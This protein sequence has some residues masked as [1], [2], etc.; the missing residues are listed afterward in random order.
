MDN[1]SSVM[2]K[3]RWPTPGKN[4]EARFITGFSA[5]HAE[6]FIG[7]NLNAIL[8]T[9][10]VKNLDE[11]MGHPPNAIVLPSVGEINVHTTYYCSS[12]LV[13]KTPSVHGFIIGLLLAAKVS[14]AE[15]QR[16]QLRAN[17][18]SLTSHLY[19]IGGDGVLISF[20]IVTFFL[21]PRRA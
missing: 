15:N 18:N 8:C 19:I 4:E 16:K 14:Q 17:G 2:V 9:R 13:Q 5:S 12:C 21:F 7:V 11:R 3:P 20:Q 10:Q 6:N 1:G